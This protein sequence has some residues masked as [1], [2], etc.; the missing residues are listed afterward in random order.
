MRNQSVKSITVD[1]LQNKWPGFIQQINGMEEKESNNPQLFYEVSITLI[2]KPGKTVQEK[3]IIGK[4]PLWTQMQK[5]SLS[6]RTE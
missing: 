3:K 5:F 4:Y 6:N 1:I 2:T